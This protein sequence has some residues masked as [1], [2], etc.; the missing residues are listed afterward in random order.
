MGYFKDLL[1]YQGGERFWLLIDILAYLQYS[2]ILQN[3]LLH[4]C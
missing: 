1:S 3:N 2:D 4:T